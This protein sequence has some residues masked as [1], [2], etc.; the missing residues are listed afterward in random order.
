MTKVGDVSQPIKAPSAWHVVR[1]DERRPSRVR[2]YEEVRDAIM[3]TLRQRYVA[4]QREA[5]VQSVFRDPET[6]TNQ[7]AIDALVRRVDPEVFRQ[8][9]A[10]TSKSAPREK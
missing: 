9:G 1:L 4:E 6:E 10:D 8:P 7:A 2:P 3:A 5:R